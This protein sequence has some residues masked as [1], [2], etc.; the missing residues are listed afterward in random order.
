MIKIPVLNLRVIKLLVHAQ[1]FSNL[2]VQSVSEGAINDEKNSDMDQLAT[3]VSNMSPQVKARL[4][5]RIDNQPKKLKLLE[6]IER[7][8]EVDNKWLN[9][10]LQYPADNFTNLYTLKNRL[11][12]DIIEVMMEL[13]R[14]NLVLT[15]EKVQSLRALVYSRDKF[16][17]I[18]ELKR[19]EK[20]AQQYELL[21]ELKEI[22]FCFFLTF[23]N[24][25]KKSK[26]YLDLM[27]EYDKQ[28]SD[29]YKLERLF[30]SELLE[31]Q[32]LFY[33]FNEQIY[34]AALHHLSELQILHE[35]LDVKSSYFLY[36]SAELT[37]RLSSKQAMGDALSL[38]VELDQMNRLYRETFLNHKYPNCEV[39]IQCLYSRF[40]F[41]V[42]KDLDFYAE[43]S[44]IRKKLSKVKGY[45][46]F[47]CNYF[48]FIYASLIKN[49]MVGDSG[50]SLLLLNDVMMN[51][52]VSL[53]DNKMRVYV[54]YVQALHLLLQQKFKA[55]SKILFGSR[56]Y[57]NEL[58]PIARWVVIDN[59]LL[60][61]LLRLHLRDTELLELEIQLLKRKTRKLNYDQ[62]FLDHF[63]HFV[64]EVRHF[65]RFDDRERITDFFLELQRSLD[66]LKAVDI[67][68][69]LLKKEA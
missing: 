28:Q 67:V 15:K 17:L 4:I 23:R 65:E 57:F 52:E 46:M 21:N 25:S 13:T 29:H 35:R 10:L 45:Q 3:T 61:I 44:A 54:L 11:F 32:D 51:T 40:Y 56:S 62:Q 55:S 16:S 64:Q 1:P 34:Q 2:R 14:T 5:K 20:N 60:N 12:D 58:E 24:D 39:A 48:Y 66:V 47:D 7:D 37:L 53:R 42:G 18:R 38:K 19:Q 68:E 9:K 49:R 8:H 33:H 41:L 59:I 27:D 69:V 6:L 50:S 36:T 26:H 30:Y 31:T 43:Q 22:Y 63:R